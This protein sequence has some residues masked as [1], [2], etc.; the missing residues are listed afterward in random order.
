[1][2]NIAARIPED[3]ARD[4]VYL[5]KEERT[6]KSKIMRELLSDAVKRRMLDMALQKY[7]KKVISLG[8]AAEIARLPL[9]DFMKEAADRKIPLNYS[10]EDLRDDIKTAK[11]F[12]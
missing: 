10:L 12:K 9:A 6:D 5:A 8:R 1:M 2:A 3:I 7:S 11:E 4:I